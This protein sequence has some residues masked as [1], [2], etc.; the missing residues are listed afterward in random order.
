MARFHG[1]QRK[2]AMRAVRV[3]KRVEAIARNRETRPERRKAARKADATFLADMIER[4]ESRG[5]DI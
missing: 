3:L 4:T 1:R 5:Y 2:G